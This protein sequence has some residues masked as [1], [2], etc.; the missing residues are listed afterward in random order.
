MATVELTEARLDDPLAYLSLDA[1][2]GHRVEGRAGVLSTDDG[3][4]VDNLSVVDA[5]DL[6]TEAVPAPGA[7]DA[8]RGAER[9]VRP[10]GIRAPAGRCSATPQVTVVGRPARVAGGDR[11][12]SAG[13]VGTASLLLRDAPDGD[14]TVETKLTIDLG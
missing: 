2:R 6:V 9:R 7:R 10:G 12:T 1:A 14:W 13:R 3:L 11:R 5:A 4:G 8:P